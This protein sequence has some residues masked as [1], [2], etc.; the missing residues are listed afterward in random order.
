[1]YTQWDCTRKKGPQKRVSGKMIPWK[2]NPRKIVLGHSKIPF[3]RGPFFPGKMIPW[4]KG[5]RKKG[6][7]KNGLRKNGTLEKKSP[8]KWSLENMYA[9]KRSPEKRS[10]LKWYPEKKSPEK[11][12]SDILKYHFSG[13]YFSLKKWCLEKKVRGK[14]VFRKMVPWK[15]NPRKNG[16]QTF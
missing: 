16:P 5:T 3:F 2:K 10:S 13:D 9:E 11:W 14:T 15:K 8:T 6:T 1:M 12:S 4:K 7:R